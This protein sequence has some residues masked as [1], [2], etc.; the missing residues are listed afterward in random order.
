M[1]WKVAA[2]FSSFLLLLSLMILALY[3]GFFGRGFGFRRFDSATVVTQIRQL[4]QLVTVR[5][6]IQRVVGLTEEKQPLGE[7]SL[8]LMVE[9]E[10]L[11]GVDLAGVKPA[12][13]T[14]DGHIFTISLPPARILNVFIDEKQTKVW[15]H[16]VTWWTPW[17]P[18]DPEME[19]RARLSALDDVRSAALKMGILDNAQRNAQAAIRDFLRAVHVDAQFKTR[20]V[21]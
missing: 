21:D 13:A 3:I 14:Y 10:A 18:Y 11:A 6:T 1:K 4:N 16:H 17:V 20:N 19:H 5:Y 15:D 9:G 8:L 12:D 7:E 2:V